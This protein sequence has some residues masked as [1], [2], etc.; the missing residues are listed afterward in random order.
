M[1]DLLTDTAAPYVMIRDNWADD[2]QFSPWL[3]VV[4][5]NIALPPTMSEATLRWRYGSIRKPGDDT[6]R[7]YSPPLDGLLK[8]WVRI[9]Q[10]DMETVLWTGRITS[11]RDMPGGMFPDDVN[12]RIPTGDMEFKAHGLEYLLN[13]YCDINGSHIYDGSQLQLTDAIL[14]FNLRP[15]R[16]LSLTGNRS[17]EKHALPN[18]VECYVFSPNGVEWTAYDVIEYLLAAWGP[19]EPYFTL[20]E[21]PASENLKKVI[22]VWPQLRQLGENISAIARRQRGFAWGI[23]Y[24]ESAE[25]PNIGITSVFDS[26]VTLAGVELVENQYQYDV[27][28]DE[29]TASL[30][31]EDDDVSGLVTVETTKSLD[32]QYDEIV[33]EGEPMLVCGTVSV[34]SGT[35]KAGWKGTDAT[36]YNTA[37]EEERRNTRY[38][39]VYAAFELAATKAEQLFAI[40]DG[41]RGGPPKIDDNGK[42]DWENPDNP[43]GL[44]LTGKTLQRQIPLANDAATF[45]PAT[46]DEFLTPLVWIKTEADDLYVPLHKLKDYDET[47]PNL[48]VWMLDDRL[49]F[50]VQPTPQHFLGLGQFTGD[51][52]KLPELDW[53]K[54]YATVALWADERLSVRVVLRTVKDFPRRL[55]IRVPDAQ[56]WVL[57][58]STKWKVADGGSSLGGHPNGTDG[59]V[60]RND[61]E[62]LAAVAA[63]AKAWYGKPRRAIKLDYKRFT[64]NFLPGEMIKNLQVNGQSTSVR[65][66]ISNVEWNFEEGT[67]TVQ[68]DFA[69]LDAVGM[70]FGGGGSVGVGGGGSMSAAPAA[71]I[72]A[73]TAQ[74]Q[75]QAEVAPGGTSGTLGQ[76]EPNLPAIAAA[77]PAGRRVDGLPGMVNQL[78]SLGGIITP[79]YDYPMMIDPEE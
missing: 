60:L 49:G 9:I 43:A 56:C 28:L 61:R 17:K 59:Q 7:K 22:D 30:D 18:G 36:A 72:S 3:D 76:A 5:C 12:R 1:T 29:D 51:A 44:Y 31:V 53:R 14:P 58:P 75:A 70:V 55:R 6:F 78:T 19:E 69:E 52:D 8:C 10:P 73:A 26:P 48:S 77:E 46:P 47:Y 40:G 79:I 2:W 74:G 68:T 4:S 45:T 67:T 71:M 66:V 42:V 24:P 41:T 50:R 15:A 54:L 39:K 20:Y 38:R 13:R 25:E 33:V 23:V 64:T 34:A 35:L 32:A 37:S 11:S 63:M 62:R 57:M 65:A 16:G 21:A 27:D